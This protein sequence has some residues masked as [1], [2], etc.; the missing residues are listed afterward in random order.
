LIKVTGDLSN[1]FAG[2]TS[3]YV[4]QAMLRIGKYYTFALSNP[5]TAATTVAFSSYPGFLESLDDF[6]ITSQQLIVI[7]T[8]NAI[9]NTS[10]YSIVRDNKHVLLSWQRT[11]LANRMASSGEEWAQYYSMYNS[12]TYNNQWIVVDLKRFKRYD[13]VRHG[14]L[15]ILEQIPGL[16]EF[17]DESRILE[18]GYWSS[19]NVPFFDTIYHISGYA[20]MAK[21]DPIMSSYDTCCRAN[22]FRRDQHKAITLK[23]YKDVL[24]YNDYQHD[25]YSQGNPGYSISARFDL[26]NLSEQPQ[27]FGG[28]DNKV[29]D[30]EMAQNLMFEALSGPTDVQQPSF[31]WTERNGL[32]TNQSHVGQ[33]NTFAFDYVSFKKKVLV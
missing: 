31:S 18:K 7:E 5:T 16:I 32:F 24:R 2:H 9:F 28:Y 27:A 25:P 19:Y 33:P 15:T 10:L 21:I 3:W 4:Y 14:T 11:L 30:Y 17:G 1:L 13:E 22:I 23:G 6:Y 20:E 26:E 29:T 8:S 12:G